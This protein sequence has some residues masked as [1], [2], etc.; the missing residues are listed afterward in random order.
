MYDTRTRLCAKF[1]EK[2]IMLNYFDIFEKNDHYSLHSIS[3]KVITYNNFIYTK[4]IDIQIQYYRK[5]F[6]FCPS[7]KKTY[8]N[9]SPVS[10]RR[11]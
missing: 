2:D 3:A 8:V 4:L 7:R 10:V 5:Y 11:Q 9:S 6:N 1:L